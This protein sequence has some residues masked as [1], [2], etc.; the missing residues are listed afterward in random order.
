MAHNEA[1]ITA[2][3]TR[4]ARVA[5]QAQRTRV[6]SLPLAA[7]ARAADGAPLAC[8]EGH[9]HRA[10]R[11]VKLARPRSPRFSSRKRLVFC[12]NQVDGERHR[13]PAV[14]KDRFKKLRRVHDPD[15]SRQTAL[16]LHS[17]ATR[18]SLASTRPAE[19]RSPP[20]RR[21]SSGSLLLPCH[22]SGHLPEKAGK[23][24]PR[25]AR[26]VSARQALL[27]QDQ[28]QDGSCSLAHRASFSSRPPM[29][30]LPLSTS[31]LAGAQQIG[32]CSSA[33]KTS[34]RPFQASH[35]GDIQRRLV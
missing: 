20:S 19:T 6:H 23:E 34:R 35:V 28:N 7:A 16:K 12:E 32:R 4:Q 15:A 10:A 9:R 22:R 26:L 21:A 30:P 24:V 29:L 18:R 14:V 3:T 1:S 31:L 8:G 17:C 25:S 13:E 2:F 5:V 33:A 11:A 27:L